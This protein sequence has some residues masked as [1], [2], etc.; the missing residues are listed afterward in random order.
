MLRLRRRALRE[1]S[2]CRADESHA[3]DALD[4]I[5]TKRESWK[6]LLEIL[7]QKLDVSPEAEKQ[8]PLLY[9]VADIQERLCWCI[10]IFIFYTNV[11]Q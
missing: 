7:S 5:Y 8:L 6:D 4:A 1:Q 10:I 2:H 3:L 9:R 11:S